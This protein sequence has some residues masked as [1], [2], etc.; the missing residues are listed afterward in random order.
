M[1]PF[2]AADIRFTTKAPVL[3][4][5]TLGMPSGTVNIT[6]LANAGSVKRVELVG[7]NTP[8]AF[9]QDGTGL[10]VTVPPG[11]SHEFGVALK[12]SGDGLAG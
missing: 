11:A 9:T 12:I 7:N 10:H 4:A 1:K 5:M 2:E 8:L 3:Y 6:S